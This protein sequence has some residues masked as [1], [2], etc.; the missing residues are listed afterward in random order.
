MTAEHGN[1]PELHSE[2]KSQEQEIEHS[3]KAKIWRAY[4]NPHLRAEMDRG[5]TIEEVEQINLLVRSFLNDVS[6]FHINTAKPHAV[7]RQRVLVDHLEFDVKSN[8]EEE[9]LDGLDQHL[10]QSLDRNELKAAKLPQFED[11]NIVR[12]FSH[13]KDPNKAIL[14]CDFLTPENTSKSDSRS[15][16]NIY[17][18]IIKKDSSVLEFLRSGQNA[19]IIPIIIRNGAVAINPD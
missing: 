11:G 13:P 2:I 14:S 7:E 15:S 16:S 12:I 1:N 19:G 5:L 9:D 8:P 18:I 4:K 6:T 17:T 3:I 10:K